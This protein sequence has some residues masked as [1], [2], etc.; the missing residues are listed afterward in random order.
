MII[1]AVFALPVTAFADEDKT[2]PEIDL[3][4]LTVTLPDGKDTVSAGDS[5][6]A[7]FKVSDESELENIAIVFYTP[8]RHH[9]ADYAA[10]GYDSETKT[11]T[12]TIPINGK[13]EIGEWKVLAI[14]AQDIYE[15]MTLIYNSAIADSY[16]IPEGSKTADFS[17]C[18]FTVEQS[19]EDEDAPVIDAE[20][21][22]AEISEG[23]D[24]AE[25][26]DVIK[27]SLSVSDSSPISDVTLYYTSP[28]RSFSHSVEAQLNA[29]S[30]KYE[31]SID[32]T[33]ST[34]A[35]L[36]EIRSISATDESG[37]TARVYALNTEGEKNTADLSK[38]SYTVSRSIKNASIQINKSAQYTGAQIKPEPIVTE[39][40]LTLVKGRDYTVS[41]K[42]NVSAGIA[43][44]TVTGI[45]GYTEAAEAAFTIIRPAVT[46]TV[47]K[48][49][50]SKITK[51]VKGSKKF[52]VKWK[53]ISGVTGYQIQYSTNKKFK[54]AKKKTV[55]GAKKYKLTV[56]KLKAKKKYYVRIRT[57]KK[58]NGK[59]YYSSWSK[60][61]AVKTK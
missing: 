3:A 20:S 52:T 53:K 27:V 13:T 39:N 60:A 54:S 51:L 18:S 29:G 33:D 9:E 59:T 56:K 49:K 46:P 15:N 40:G 12:F 24:R 14:G 19:A 17:A 55:K 44:V 2:A 10:G 57:Y 23:K 22:I 45:G 37:N 6:T 35:G 34:E 16:E 36:W 47:A 5:V 8:I 25:A 4:S 31:S 21:L 32:I 50:A 38:G 26:G 11:A 48:P 42:N 30:G 7:A 43:T 58:V 41:Y 28:L 1:S 61:K